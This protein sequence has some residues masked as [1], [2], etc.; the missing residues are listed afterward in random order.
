MTPQN[1][2][3]YLAD[4]LKELPEYPAPPNIRRAPRVTPSQLSG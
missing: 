4:I 1:H 2:I 3:N